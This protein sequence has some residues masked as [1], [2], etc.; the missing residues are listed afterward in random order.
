MSDAGEV[1]EQFEGAPQNQMEDIANKLEKVNDTLREFQEFVRAQMQN[2]NAFQTAI[3]ERLPEPNTA[4]KSEP[5][6]KPGA[7]TEE[8]PTKHVDEPGA[9]AGKPTSSGK[10]DRAETTPSGQGQP[11]KSKKEQLTIPNKEDW[12]KAVDI[13]INQGFAT[14]HQLLE[15][16]YTKEEYPVVFSYLCAFKDDML[17]AAKKLVD[18][19]NKRLKLRTSKKGVFVDRTHN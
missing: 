6:A 14:V 4:I 16:K 17:E 8:K 3:L 12:D 10:R 13:Y 11:K 7:K 2:I 9:S 5:A 19:S 18:N 15:Y 1:D